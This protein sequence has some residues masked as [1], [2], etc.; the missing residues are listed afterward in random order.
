NDFCDRQLLPELMDQLDANIAQVSGDGAH[1]MSDCF[2]RLMR[3]S[4]GLL[5]HRGTVCV[6]DSMVTLEVCVVESR[7]E[8]TAHPAL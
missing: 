4:S 5:F 2:Q 8:P 3:A 6:S 1:D 7:R